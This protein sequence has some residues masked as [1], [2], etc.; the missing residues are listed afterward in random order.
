MLSFFMTHSK[1][2]IISSAAVTQ[3]FND[4]RIIRDGYDFDSSYCIRFSAGG[5]I[6]MT[7]STMAEAVRDSPTGPDFSDVDVH[8]RT[9]FL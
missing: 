6:Y 8:R 5:F 9:S 3:V 7:E 2:F 1:D 4:V